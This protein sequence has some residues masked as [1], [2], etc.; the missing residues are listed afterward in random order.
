M[1]IPFVLAKAHGGIAMLLA[2]LALISLAMALKALVTGSNKGASSLANI[3]GL[4]ET[5]VAGLVTLTGLV[6]IFVSPWPLSQ[7]WIWIGLVLMV[8]YSVSLKRL[9]KPARLAVAEGDSAKKWAGFQLIQLMLVI[10]SFALMHL[11]P[12]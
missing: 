8:L 5:I 11:K 3:A 7:A 6:L 1:N 12:F 9:T 2:L 4:V 10:I